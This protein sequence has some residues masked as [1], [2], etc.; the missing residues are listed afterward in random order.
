MMPETIMPVFHVSDRTGSC[1]FACSLPRQIK[2]SY[3]RHF[4]RIVFP[5]RVTWNTPKN[6]NRL[7]FR[8]AGRRG[9]PVNGL[10]YTVPN[11][12]RGGARHQV[13]ALGKY[14]TLQQP[15]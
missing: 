12:C 14:A 8:G 1:M 9:V 10:K 4:A 7:T 6:K 15:T 11:E 3:G 2:P 13:Y 5:L